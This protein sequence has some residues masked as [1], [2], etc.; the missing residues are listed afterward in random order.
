[1]NNEDLVI[2][3]EQK[4][5]MFNQNIDDDRKMLNQVFVPVEEVQSVSEAERL[6]REDYPRFDGW[7]CTNYRI[8]SSDENKISV[9]LTMTQYDNIKR[10]R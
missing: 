5:V 10:S 9:I 6:I 3:P 2:K 7:E 1:M 8:T 4:P